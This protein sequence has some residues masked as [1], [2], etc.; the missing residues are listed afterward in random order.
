MN[1][2]LTPR[3]RDLTRRGNVPDR[4]G[5]RTPTRTRAFADQPIDSLQIAGDLRTEG[6][7]GGD[8]C[9]TCGRIASP[10]QGDGLRT[11]RM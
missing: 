7:S 4:T 10:L 2:W 9:G 5:W 6:T 8:L 11:C 3:Q 1:R